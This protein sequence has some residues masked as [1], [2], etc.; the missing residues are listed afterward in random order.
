MLEDPRDARELAAKLGRALSDPSGARR[1]FAE[2]SERLRER[3]WE[4]CASE[5]AA[6][7]RG[8]RLEVSGSGSGSGAGAR[9]G[10][11]SGGVLR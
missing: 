4:A 8:D 10:V 2:F 11:G 7:G 6:L 1:A 5:I 9:E 3:D